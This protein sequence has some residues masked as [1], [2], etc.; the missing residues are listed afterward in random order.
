M[1]SPVDPAKTREAIATMAANLH[2]A[3]EELGQDPVGLRELAIL[4]AAG[5]VTS[6]L[7]VL[8]HAVVYV[9]DAIRERRALR[10]G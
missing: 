7:M 5:M 8:A 4:N 1:G 10:H 6:G 2:K 9:G 3:R